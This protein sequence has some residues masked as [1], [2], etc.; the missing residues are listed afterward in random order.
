MSKLKEFLVGNPKQN[1]N[2]AYDFPNSTGSIVPIVDIIEGVIITDDSR[3]VKILEVLPV[4]FNL[5]SE[6]E[7]LNIIWYMAG[8]LKVAP[9]NLQILVRTEP[10]DI[11]A[12]CE[13]M[14]EYYNSEAN[15]KCKEMIFEDAQLV[16][17]LAETQAVTRKFYLV[18]SYEGTS[19]EF[20]EIVKDLNEKADTARQYLE[21]CGLEAI[22]HE[23]YN[24]FLFK[25]LHSI[26]RR[27]SVDL[28]FK[29]IESMM[30]PLHSDT[31]K[32][33]SNKK[34]IGMVSYRDLLSPDTYDRTNKGFLI[35][36]GVYH[37]YFYV[38]GYGYPTET[39]LAWLSPLVEMGDG[40]SVSFYLNRKPKDQILKKIS[41]TTMMNRARMK[42][43]ED[44]RTDFEEMDDAISSGFYIK[45][46]IQKKER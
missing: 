12:Y 29:E 30:V 32:R 19:T 28:D 33:K 8:Y 34:D 10:A 38:A 40:V 44:T 23:N 15:E 31:K 35:T 2:T 39:D 13:R 5:K 20:K 9:N 43:I 37:S 11:D 27:D 17:F 22:A 14:E 45:E 25:T 41:K 4:N 16:N 7:Q 18:F 24:E 46:K 3:F 1:E 42:D 26:F 21:Y 36:D 6:T